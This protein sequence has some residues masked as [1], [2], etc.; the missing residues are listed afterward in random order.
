MPDDPIESQV[1]P[2]VDPV[3]PPND[4]PVDPLTDP[5]PVVITEPDPLEEE[6]FR[7]VKKFNRAVKAA[8]EP[9]EPQNAPTPPT[10]P[11]PEVSSEPGPK[12]GGGLLDPFKRRR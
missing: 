9:K 8:K 4:P 1:D 7:T 6:T 10:P 5:T 2:P 3:D 12:A 11:T